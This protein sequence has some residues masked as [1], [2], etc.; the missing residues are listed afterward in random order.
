MS[1][2][3]EVYVNESEKEDG[4]WIGFVRDVTGPIIGSKEHSKDRVIADLKLKLIS[5]EYI[6]KEDE[7]GLDFEHFKFTVRD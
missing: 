5:H 2:T 4:L 7:S 3:F 1:K 6:G